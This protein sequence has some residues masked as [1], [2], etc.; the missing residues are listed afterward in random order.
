MSLPFRCWDKSLYAFLISSVRAAC[1][2]LSHSYL[3]TLFSKEYTLQSASIC[4]FLFLP[5]TSFPWSLNILWIA[6]FSRTVSLLLLRI[7]S[8]GVIHITR[9]LIMWWVTPIQNSPCNCSFVCFNP[10]V[11]R[12]QI[13]RQQVAKSKVMG[14]PEFNLLSISLWI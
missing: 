13:E 2:V 5:V 6:L 12:W 7:E 4:I 14:L 3:I 9:W 1:S 10:D 11:F 8:Y